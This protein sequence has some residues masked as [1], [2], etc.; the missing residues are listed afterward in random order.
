MQKSQPSSATGEGQLV[1]WFFALTFAFTWA[2]QGPGAL[3]VVGVLPGPVE[4]YL[5]FAALGIFGPSVAASVLVWRA[6]R[7]AGVRALW[8]SLFRLGAPPVLY[9]VALVLPGALLSAALFAGRRL[10]Y[11][12]PVV[13]L[14]DPPATVIVGLLISVVEEVG[15]RGYLLPR[16]QQRI[17]A[18]RASLALGAIWTVW[19]LP[20]FVGQGIPLVSLP[21]MFGYFMAGSVFMAWVYNRGGG[22][23][24]AAVLV[25]LGAHLNNAHRALPDDY[26]PLIAQTAVFVMLAVLIV[27]LDRSGL[28]PAGGARTGDRG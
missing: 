23:L 28:E 2:L 9:L 5:P 4:A 21:L 27:W 10:G 11:A 14:P 3:A 13:F 6:E 17:G 12:G 25:H 1:L 18:L 15:W 26:A 22:S 20:M 19:H 16:W 8:G 7:G 24:L